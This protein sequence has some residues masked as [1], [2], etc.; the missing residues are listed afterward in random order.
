VAATAALLTRTTF[1]ELSRLRPAKPEE[2]RAGWTA[3][4][5]RLFIAQLLVAGL[6]IGLI[7]LLRGLP[8]WLLPGEEQSQ[9]WQVAADVAAVIG[10]VAEVVLWPV[11]VLALLLA[12]VMVVEEV[13]V[14]AGLAHWWR[15]LREHPG[16][17]LL[18]EVLAVGVGLAVALVPALP[19]LFLGQPADDR[20][21]LAAATT[22][23]VLLG[24]PA[25]L[26]FAYVT[27]ANVFI[28]LHLRYEAR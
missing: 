12:P 2:V 27:V 1:I 22:R 18:Y 4:A 15:L 8:Q 14:E 25:A 26:L 3:R 7:V 24:L 11:V 21:S 6:A 28:Y 23:N 10:V 19:L 17:V 20:L 5:V 16:S 13:G 9:A